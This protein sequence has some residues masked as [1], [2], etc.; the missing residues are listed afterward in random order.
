MDTLTDVLALSAVE[1]SV[2]AS[3]A[4]GEPWGVR[5]DAV[6]GAAFHAVT[7]GTA[8]LTIEGRPPLHLMPGDAVLLPGGIAHALASSADATVTPFD[9]RAAEAALERGAVLAVGPA[10]ASTHVLCASYRHEPVASLATFSLL[11]DV[12]HVRSSEAPRGLRT[13]LQ[14]IADEL[15][16]PGPGL[17][18]VLDHAVNVLLVQLLRA[19]VSS[20]DA[21]TTPPSWLR[22]LA[23]PVTR[24]ALAELHGDPGRAWTTQELARRAG[25]SRATLGRRFAAEVGQSPGDY[26]TTWRMAVAAR[27]LRASDDPVAAVAHGVGYASEYA[28]NRAFARHHGAPPGRYR[29]AQRRFAADR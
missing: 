23:D 2:A 25:V 10:P 14:L 15:A 7:A 18:T 1:G 3:L 12:V 21:P 11:P 26:L 8:W 17:R 24:A 19:W 9:H 20:A 29:S 27:R 6:P 13:T 22:G 16:D 28:F 5:L 4:A